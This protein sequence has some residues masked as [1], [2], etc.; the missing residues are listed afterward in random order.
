MEG[1]R[2]Y[3]LQRWDGASKSDPITSSNGS[4]AAEINAFFAS[5][6]AINSHS[7]W[8]RILLQ[9][10]MSIMQYLNQKLI[11]QRVLGN[12]LLQQNKGY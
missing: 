2:W 1:M 4:M 12:A 10:K 3:D 6:K 11:T 9:A 5:D 8:V 7:C